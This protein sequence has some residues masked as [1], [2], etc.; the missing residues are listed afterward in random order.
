MAI[1]AVHLGH[2]RALEKTW[3]TEFTRAHSDGGTAVVT[4]GS[5]L[6]ARLAKLIPEPVAG[7]GFF[8]GI[9]LLARS[10]A[11]APT[12]EKISVPQSIALAYHAGYDANS[13]A[14]AAGFFENLLESGITSEMFDIQSKSLREPFPEV[15]KTAERFLEYQKLRDS[16][17][18][19]TPD[20]AMRKGPAGG[21]R[22]KTVM[23]YGFYDLNPGQRNYIKKLAAS[24]D[25]LWFSP[26]HPSH[27]WRKAFERTMGFLK[28]LCRGEELHR[29]DGDH[30]LSPAA[31]FAENL[32]TGKALQENR[33]ISLKR[34]GSGT[35]FTRAVVNEIKE[36]NTPYGDVAVVASGESAS[37]IRTEL[38]CWGIPCETDLAVRASEL[39]WGR[40]IIR[41][42]SLA[43]NRCH[44][45]AIEG[46]LA[47]G[48]VTAPETPGPEEYSRKAAGKG[49]RFGIGDMV[50]TGF[51]FTK[52]IAAYFG[53]MPS[54]ARP[55]DY[56]QHLNDTLRALCPDSL[57]GYCFDAVLNGRKFDTDGEIPFP[58]FR[59]LV[60]KALDEP[61]RIAEGDRKGVCILSPERARGTLFRAIILT[62]MEEGKFP[63]RTVNDPR[64]PVEMKELLQMPS[65]DDRE[66]EDAFL[67]RQVFEAAGEKLVILAE[68]TDQKGNAVMLSPFLSRLKNDPEN[69]NRDAV[70]HLN[71][72]SMPS[73][74]LD[75]PE[76]PPFLSSSIQAQRER[77]LFDGEDPSPGSSHCGMI[78][79]GFFTKHRISAT[80]LENYLRNPFEFMAEYLWKTRSPEGFP[81]RSEPAPLNRGILVH[82]CVELS[83]AA[84][85]PA[86]NIVQ[87]TADESGLEI[88]LGS[89][90]L[91]EIWVK[92][93]AE[94]V[95][96][97][98][99]ELNS[100]N[101][102]FRGS[103]IRLEG[104]VAGYPAEGRID[105]IF[106]SC[107][108]GLVLADLKTGRP[109]GA[110]GKNMLSRNK[111][112]LPFYRSLALQNGY[113]P[114]LSACYI[115]LEGNG[116]VTFE[117]VPGEE[118]ESIHDRFETKVR[119]TVE[120]MRNGVFPPAK[121][122]KWRQ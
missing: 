51:P 114:I 59:K 56:L 92:H 73:V 74:T 39:P 89:G 36:L 21:D 42:N 3:V 78:G 120:N 76:D 65:P 32:L 10:L 72:P 75:F 12:S 118:L 119:E 54:S 60:E 69:P 35:A 27:H 45:S 103:E 2:W 112:Q 110:T 18:P 100:R 43:D 111:L 87:R 7:A 58:L 40:L 34:C 16:G 99:R 38:Y 115:H 116:E 98:R 6:S 109:A 33:E 107:G 9:P 19:F 67:L 104:A 79:P 102:T 121:E 101:W 28:D 81:V 84:D 13:A 91:A 64:L 106:E 93:T 23:F 88:M 70:R 49:A 71:I 8:P 22:Y 82:K 20:N 37:S 14:A 62:G 11:G 68:S 52:A 25:I 97:L 83:L 85:A 122:K 55:K 29:V 30:P 50:K 46:L 44:H 66:T 96:R 94:A 90:K 24:T 108:E 1:L 26:V 17:F 41:L 80:M 77:L 5:H 57:P 113:K 86:L 31:Q 4:A 61:V 48:M 63:G 95:E 53:K 105:L 15:K 117:E 47:T